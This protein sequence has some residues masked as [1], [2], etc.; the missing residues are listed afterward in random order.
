MFWAQGYKK[1]HTIH[2]R[3]LYVQTCIFL[4]YLKYLYYLQNSI[5]TV[6]KLFGIVLVFA[7]SSEF[8]PQQV[9]KNLDNWSYS[10]CL[11]TVNKASGSRSKETLLP[12][13]LKLVSANCS[14]QN[15]RLI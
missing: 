12:L 6:F 13:K 4:S 8:W 1:T 5:Q 2:F 10:H 3:R 11:D 7:N 14:L 9:A 15:T